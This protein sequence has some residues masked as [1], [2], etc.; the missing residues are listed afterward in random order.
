MCHNSRGYLKRKM[1]SWEKKGKSGT[2]LRYIFFF[3]NYW[4]Y[5]TTTRSFT[6]GCATQALPGYCM[7]LVFTAMD[8]LTSTSSV[9]ILHIFQPG[10]PGVLC[11][12]NRK[13]RQWCAKQPS[14]AFKANKASCENR[15]S[16]PP[17]PRGMLNS[18]SK[19]TKY[20]DVHATQTH[21]VP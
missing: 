8:T 6:G 16:I 14:S 20:K 18:I 4:K 1:F 10:R 11:L 7:L 17:Q 3:Q 12:L 9:E 13:V 2:Q 5:Y 15:A 19:R 21:P